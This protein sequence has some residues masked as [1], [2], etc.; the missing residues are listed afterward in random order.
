MCISLSFCIHFYSEP[1]WTDVL[2]NVKVDEFRE[3]AGPTTPLPHDI[4]V[5][6][7]FKLFFTTALMG[8]IVEQTNTY[9][10]LVL[11]ENP[12]W[13][14]VTDTDIWAFLGFCILM[15][16]NRLPALHHY[17]SPDPLFHY[18]PIAECISR[19]RFLSI[20]QFLHFVNN[21]PTTSPQ[22]THGGYL[23]STPPDPD[24]LWKISPVVSAVVGG[25]LPH[26][27]QAESGG[28]Y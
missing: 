14:D 25:C 8:T 13:T 11:G 7:L 5:L 19:G 22:G 26:P 10:R 28:K 23:S 17:W 2:T 24:R 1:D 3:I 6:S 4:S 16:I 12:R 18:Q 9:V 27:L 15:G 21:Q 20:W